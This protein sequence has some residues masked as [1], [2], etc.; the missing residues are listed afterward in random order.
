MVNKSLQRIIEAVGCNSKDGPDF[1]ILIVGYSWKKK[2]FQI[3]EMRYRPKDQKM[4]ASRAKTIKKIKFG[5]I[6]DA[7]TLVRKRLHDKLANDGI[8]DNGDIDMQP[9]EVLIEYIK[10]SQYRSIDGMP[11]MIKIYPYM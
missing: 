2:D 9:L 3:F 5:V 1:S 4:I 6:G 10:D 11:Q 8:N 7:V